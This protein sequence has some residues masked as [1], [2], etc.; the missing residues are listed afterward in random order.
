MLITNTTPLA[1]Y[2][3]TPFRWPHLFSSFRSPDSEAPGTYNTALLYATSDQAFR[4]LDIGRPERALPLARFVHERQPSGFSAAL[5][6][7]SLRAANRHEDLRAF[8]DSLPERVL[9]APV[10]SIVL[11]LD[12]RD[13]GQEDFARAHLAGASRR[14]RSAALDRALNSPMAA[15][16][17][18]LHEFLVEIADPSR[19][20]AHPPSRADGADSDRSTVSFAHTTP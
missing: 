7:E 19:A 17:R 3:L 12:A 13:L 5:V 18:S 11:A 20:P 10:L 6:A 8:R 14:L 9:A 4:N 16:P 15:W 1:R 2:L